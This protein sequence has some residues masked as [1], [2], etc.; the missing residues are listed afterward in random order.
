M[1]SYA[2]TTYVT[3]YFVKNCQLLRNCPH[4]KIIQKIYQHLHRL[5]LHIHNIFE[6]RVDNQERIAKNQ[7]QF[8]FVIKIQ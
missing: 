6:F 4:A 1:L 2:S 3:E 7:G 8:L 5:N